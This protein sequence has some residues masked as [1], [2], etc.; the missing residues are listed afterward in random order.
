MVWHKYNPTS[1]NTHVPNKVNLDK[2]GIVVQSLLCP[3]CNLH[4]ETI[5]HVLTSIWINS[6]GSG[7]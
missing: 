3:I 6:V 5:A 1:W 4:V 2:R 7:I